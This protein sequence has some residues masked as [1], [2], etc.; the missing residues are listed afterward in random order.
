MIRRLL[1]QPT[2]SPP[3]DADTSPPEQNPD[4]GPMTN[5]MLFEERTSPATCQNCHERIDG[6]GFGFESFDLAGRFRTT[7]NGLPVDAT[8]FAQGIGNDAVYDGAGEL[9]ELFAE[10]PI[11]QDCAVE[12]WF[13]YAQGHAPEGADAC[14]VDALQD[15]FRES[16][17]DLDEMVVHLV[18]R[19][20]FLLRPA[21]ET[22]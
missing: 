15:A 5:R 18:T 19:P 8:G 13:T 14:Q 22:D 7:D 9:Q 4:D 6:F 12:T 17:G 3:A 16:G 11:V 20:E 1:C 10:S 2:G 21:I